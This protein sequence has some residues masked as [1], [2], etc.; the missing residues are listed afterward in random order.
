VTYSNISSD[1]MSGTVNFSPA[2]PN[3]GSAWFGLEDTLTASTLS[4][5][6]AV[7]IAADAVTAAPAASD[8]FTVTVSNSTSAAFTVTSL[9]DTLP[10]GFAYKAGSTTGG[11]TADPAT[12][13]S[14]LTWTGTFTVPAN[15]TFTFHFGVTVSATPGSYTDSVTGNSAATLNP[16][17]ATAVITVGTV[18]TSSALPPAGVPI[19]LV[20][21]AGVI[22]L[23]W[24][25]RRR[26]PAAA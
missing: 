11:I 2:V 20:L 22:A 4:V 24:R 15:G 21:A 7:A 10:T 13:G 9:V 14:I 19:A 5:A 8:G 6:S 18:V 23:Y 3:G 16:A 26:H 1:V 17:T 12:S 25:R